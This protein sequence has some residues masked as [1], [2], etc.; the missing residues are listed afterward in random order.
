MLLPRGMHR[1]VALAQAPAHSHDWRGRVH[2]L[3]VLRLVF[4]DSTLADDIGSYVTEARMLLFFYF[5]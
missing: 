1:L 4:I 3:N 2:A 5:D